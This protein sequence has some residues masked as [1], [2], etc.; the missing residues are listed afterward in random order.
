MSHALRLG[1]AVAALIW[2][3]AGQVA[4]A[5]TGAGQAPAPITAPS[6]D[7]DVA[8]DYQAWND[9]A[10]RVEAAIEDRRA[11]DT[12]LETLRA[13][14]VSWREALL[15]AQNAN[16]ARIATLRAQIEAL[17][18]APSAG[19]VEP[20][21]LA[22][23]RLELAQQLLRIQAPAIAADEA[24]RRANGLIREI[25]RTVRERQ[26]DQL[27][28]LWP[29]PI[30]PANWPEAVIGLTDTSIRLWDEVVENW[31]DETRRSTFYSNLPLIVLVL[32]IGLALTI[33]ARAWVQDFAMRL[34]EKGSIGAKRIVA[35][36]ASLGEVVF[37]MVG[38]GLVALALGLSQMLG[39]L[40]GQITTALPDIAF[41]LIAASW[42]AGRI[43][44]RGTLGGP[45]NLGTEGRAEARVLTVLMGLMLGVDSLRIAA[46]GPQNY[47]EGTTSVTSFP[48]LVIAG[49]LLVRMG[50]MLVRHLRAV[51][52]REGGE[53]ANFGRSSLM[54]VAQACV[55][56]G[57]AGPVLGAV[58]YVAAAAALVYPATLSLGLI[59]VLLILQHLV[60]DIY[61]M[62]THHSAD[63][64]D[65]LL[66]VLANFILAVASLPLFALIWGARVADITEVW[67]RFREGFQFGTTRI[68]PTD[69]MFFA[70][71]FA[72]GYGL[73]RLLQGALKSTILP[74][75]GLDQGAQNAT[76]S[77]VGYVGIILAALI[78]INTAGIDLSGL[79]I[80]AGALS[81]GIGF[82]L[83]NIVSNFVSGII[84]LVERPVSE[85][86]WIEVGTTSGIVKSISVRST[87]IQTFD[88][89]DVIVPNTDLVA[90][91]VTNW[92]RFNL[93]GRLTVPVAVPH[94]TDSR[95]VEAILR[96]IAESQPL[97]LMNPAP[98]VALVGFGADTQNFEIRMILRDVNGQTAVRSEVNH[99]IAAR[100]SA[101]GIAFSPA[102]AARMESHA[103]GLL[104][105]PV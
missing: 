72:I 33:T 18:P 84:L 4:G 41:P 13:Q 5:Q 62:L 38:V 54:L 81:V 89:A 42:M 25:D 97:V 52:Q 76:V 21:D 36:M 96:D 77:G 46:M 92:T 71:V 91:R 14:L 45:L 2:A 82:G 44:P 56:I 19:E 15:G 88:R 78:A 63:E 16:S 43:F 49:L 26:A 100:F 75:T 29:A 79:A 102:H 105:S 51:Q 66:P 37:P 34:R 69:F 104:D 8:L 103:A 73:T 1:F 68:S 32:A 61:A 94:G 93:T 11:T 87:R 60:G 47:S 86:D 39:E 17:G 85:G 80:V 101:E 99:Q 30:N 53:S 9:M 55:V 64:G 27:L 22:D 31:A 58:G 12:A 6:G 57:L 90:G 40:G 3:A 70:V 24:Y 28:Q 74:R 48:G 7:G 23:R 20:A 50:Q 65:A 83:Q 59:A 95:R 35:L 10:A 98:I 67:T